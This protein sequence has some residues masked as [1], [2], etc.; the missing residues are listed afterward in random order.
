MKITFQD[1]H[2]SNE[3]NDWMDRGREES[4]KKAAELSRRHD[5]A[6]SYWLRQ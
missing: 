2:Q 5:F 1:M 6:E 4:A 3:I